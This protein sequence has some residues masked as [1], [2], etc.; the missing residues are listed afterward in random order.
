MKGSEKNQEKIY[1]AYKKMYI[2]NIRV[3]KNQVAEKNT[4]N[5]HK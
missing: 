5:H 3:K 1:I 4:N 2:K